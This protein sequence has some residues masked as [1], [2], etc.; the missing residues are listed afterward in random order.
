MVFSNQHF[1]KP[2]PPRDPVC[3][4]VSGAVS[5]QQIVKAYLSG[6]PV[7]IPEPDPGDYEFESTELSEF[8]RW[9]DISRED[10]RKASPTTLSIHDAAKRNTE[11]FKSAVTTEP[12]PDPEPAPADLE[13][14]NE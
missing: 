10:L 1:R 8:E 4:P 14:S 9:K 5:M 7:D 11:D 3:D 2:V 13:P 6:T 12:S